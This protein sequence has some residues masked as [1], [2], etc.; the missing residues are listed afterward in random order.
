MLLNVLLSLFGLLYYL[1]FVNK[2]I[3]LYDEGY[4]LHIADRILKGQIPY[5]DFF[6]QFFPLYF[7]ILSGVFKVVGEE[8][9]VERILTLFLCLSILFLNLKLV[10][11]LGIRSIKLKILV[12]LSI[13]SF[14]FPLIN[15]P[16]ILAWIS[17]FVVMLLNYAIVYW[18][19]KDKNIVLVGLCLALLFAL[20]Q[21]LGVYFFLL[22]NI[23]VLLNSKN[24]VKDFL[25]LNLTFVAISVSWVY[26]FFHTNW[27]LL[28]GFISHNQRYLSIYPFSYPPISFLAQPFGIFKLI[29]YYLPIIYLLILIKNFKKIKLPILFYLVSS[30]VGFFG[31]VVPTSD[32][33]HVYPFYSMILI[34]GLLV[35][36]K[37]K[38]VLILTIISIISGFYLTIFREYYRYQPGYSFQN[39][40]LKFAKAK[41]IFIDSS[42]ASQLSGVDQFIKK[43]KG[44]NSY[45]LVYP[46]SPM[47][48]FLYDINNPSRY[49]IY[50]PGYLDMQQEE[51]VLEEIK[52]KRVK[53]IIT[54]SEYKFKT[55]ISRYIERQKEVYNNGIFR[56]F[57]II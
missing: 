16:S 29:P 35:F 23:F 15:N 24:R 52:N 42:L 46:F 20:K 5:R 56:V 3:V 28:G 9:I 40:Q 45:V 53:F 17:V 44:G 22:T 1:P 14:G 55:P 36:K 33:L 25:V 49:S 50:Y 19:K 38:V 54:V 57:K 26:Y 37:N 31:T 12:F 8:I 18:L 11:K 6:L 41:G 43:N 34:G 7:Y 13:I 21:N 39:T 48:Y 4:Y 47:L 27:S 32:L 10:E 30:L 2:G 51:S